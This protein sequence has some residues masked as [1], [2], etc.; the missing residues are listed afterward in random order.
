MPDEARVEMAREGPVAVLSLAHPPGNRLTQP[1]VQELSSHLGGIE[2]DA[3]LLAVVV[4][5]KGGRTFCDGLEVEEWASF[6]PKDAQSALQRGFEALWSLE[7]LTKPT[8]AAIEGRCRSVGAEL[9]LACDLRVASE[10]ATFAFPEIDGAWMPSHGGT[11]RLPRMVGRAKALELLLTGAELRGR[12]ARDLGFVEHVTARGR[13]LG[14]AL[15]LARTFAAKPRTA[16]HAIKRALTEGE[17]KPYR[18]RFLLEA[19]HSV[20]LLWTDAYREAQE[21][22]RRKGST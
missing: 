11:A 13:T 15:D 4:T 9:A 16:V 6:S 5:G 20:Q 3:T 22:A 7:H 2:K 12:A 8:I 21:R 19:Q 17:E 18:N 14:K 1:M 10:A